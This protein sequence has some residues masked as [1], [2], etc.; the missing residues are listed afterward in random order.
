MNPDYTGVAQACPADLGCRGRWWSQRRIPTGQ[1]SLAESPRNRPYRPEGVRIVETAR[2]LVLPT[3]PPQHNLT[4]SHRRMCTYHQS[5]FTRFS[6]PVG[7]KQP[8]RASSTEVNTEK[9]DILLP[10]WERGREL[11]QASGYKDGSGC[12]E[13]AESAPSW[14]QRGTDAH[15]SGLWL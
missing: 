8:T 12:R 13:W 11:W 1:K 3:P 9:G 4:G 5:C 6:N 10:T 7:L 14:V 2:H 15:A